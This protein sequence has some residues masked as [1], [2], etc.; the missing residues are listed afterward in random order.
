MLFV[1]NY[2][3]LAKNFLIKKAEQF[4]VI[5]LWKNNYLICRSA[6]STVT[7]KQNKRKGAL[8]ENKTNI[9]MSSAQNVKR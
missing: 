8:C 3:R 4:G 2:A 1:K 9:E 5:R 7:K 6:C